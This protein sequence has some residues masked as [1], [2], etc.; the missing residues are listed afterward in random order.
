MA[1]PSLIDTNKINTRILSKEETCASAGGIAALDKKA[2]DNAVK[3]SFIVIS[4][5]A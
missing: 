1:L 2:L 3:D 5:E 4:F